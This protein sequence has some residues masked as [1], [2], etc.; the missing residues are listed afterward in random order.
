VEC[1]LF[2]SRPGFLVSANLY[3]PDPIRD[4]VPAV[5]GLCGHSEAGKAEEKYQRAWQGLA[6][7]GF[8][9]LSIDPISQGERLQ[10]RPGDKRGRRGACL[11]GLCAGHN[12]LGNQMVLRDEFFGTWRVWDAIRGLD[13]LSSRPEVDDARIGVTGNSGGGTLT[14]FVAA[15]DPRPAAVAP[16][17]YICSYLANLLNEIPS[18]AEQNP[19]GALARGLDQADLLLCH[20]PRPTLI[21]AQHDDFFDVRFARRA[22]EEVKRV[23]RMLGARGTTGFFAGPRGHGFHQ[24]NR[25]AMYR[26]FMKHLG[27][28]GSA[29]EPRTEP[30]PREE[31]WC[32]PRGEVSRAGSL[33]VFDLL[34]PVAPPELR[35]DELRKKA[36]KLLGLSRR[37]RRAELRKLVHYGGSGSKTH[38]SGQFALATEPGIQSILTVYGEITTSMHLPAGPLTVY[39]GHAQSAADVR[40]VAAVRGLIRK[41]KPLVAVDPRGFGCVAA[42]TCGGTSFFDSYGADY[43]YAATGEM[44][45]ESYLGRRTHDLLGAIDCLPPGAALLDYLPSYSLLLEDPL[46]NWP[47]SSLLRGVLRHFD[48]PDVYRELG[49]RLRLRNPWGAVI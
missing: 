32:S 12:I 39:I 24:E 6:R 45:G 14:T 23:H 15:L 11:P 47:L 9:V 34:S 22:F 29:E 40:D 2:E 18:D 19:P 4:K 35:G 7:K 38:P 10:F 46:A 31:L 13:Y 44:L 28:P 37:P 1:L 41:A 16:S 20:A 17:C 27:A 36:R 25:E 3:V 30:E 49:G 8:A 33:R 43:L 21:L 5:L 26:F 48:L 42:Q